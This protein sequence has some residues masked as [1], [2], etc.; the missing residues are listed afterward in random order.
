[1]IIGYI[2][3]G[4]GYVLGGGLSGLLVAAGG[5]LLIFLK[6][7]WFYFKKPPVS[8]ILILIVLA[9]GIY[10]FENNKMSASNY[11]HKII[12]LG[13]DGLSPKITERLMEEG[14][15]PHF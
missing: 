7:T 11:N 8:I 2:D 1:M 15:L 14:K 9:I 6:R 12:I 4:A 10:M 3:P 5:L 13:F